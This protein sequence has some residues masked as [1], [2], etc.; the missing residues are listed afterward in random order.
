MPA[1]AS[2][3]RYERVLV[4]LLDDDTVHTTSTTRDAASASETK[5]SATTPSA[6]EKP[7]TDTPATGTRP[8]FRLDTTGPV[9]S[10][11]R[12]ADVASA[13]CRVGRGEVDVVVAVVVVGGKR[14]DR[15]VSREVVGEGVG[16]G[17]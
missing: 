9:T 17:A 1:G 2:G 10:Q 6:L 12:D 14:D 15:A 7:A 11:G 8:T 13:V 5:N 16:G 3:A 4:G